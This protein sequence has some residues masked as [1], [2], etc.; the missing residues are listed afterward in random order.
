MVPRSYGWAD[1][2]GGGK[3][4]QGDVGVAGA[5][6]QWFGGSTVPGGQMVDGFDAGP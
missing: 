1:A 6:R 2:A 3:G 4:H 5:T